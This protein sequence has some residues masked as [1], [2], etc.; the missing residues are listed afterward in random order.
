MS[1]PPLDRQRAERIRRRAHAVLD[2]R[3]PAQLP[4][5]ELTLVLLFSIAQAWWAAAAVVHV[6]Q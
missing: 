6:V 2:G 3:V 4:P 5:V 1:I